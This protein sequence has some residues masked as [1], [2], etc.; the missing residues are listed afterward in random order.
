MGLCLR[1]WEASDVP[2]VLE[3]FTEPVMA[4]QADAPI[5]TVEGAEQWIQR[6]RKQWYQ[7][8]A[9]SVAVTD[10]ADV[11][12]GGVAVGNLNDRHGTGW[13]SYWTISVARG[14]GVASHGCRVLAECCFAD[15]GLFRLELGHRTDNPASCRVA[16][17]AGFTAE[18]LQR[19]KLV[20]EGVRHDVETHARLATDPSPQ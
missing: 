1:P 5:T 20:Y 8:V 19:G 12:L 17:A 3:A 9:Y 15:L 2:M 7:Q 13:I 4:R 6:R 18:G 14:K 10:H 11:A 16:L